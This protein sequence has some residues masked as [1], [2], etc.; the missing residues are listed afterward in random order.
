MKATKRCKV[1]INIK[2]T[3]KKRKKYPPFTIRIY[4][5]VL[6]RTSGVGCCFTEFYQSLTKLEFSLSTTLLKMKLLS[7]LPRLVLREYQKLKQDF[8]Y[9]GILIVQFFVSITHTI[10]RTI[11]VG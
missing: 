5:N 3:F 4:N 6:F 8:S 9:L 7:R 1:L 11:K 2:Q 10:H